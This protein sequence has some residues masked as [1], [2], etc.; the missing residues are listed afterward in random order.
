[1]KNPSGWP[2]DFLFHG[3]DQSLSK[4]Q[5]I[6]SWWDPIVGSHGDFGIIPRK[7]PPLQD[8]QPPFDS[9]RSVA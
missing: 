5:A 7:L 8:G 3:D 9:E 1:M 2:T 6:G 4:D